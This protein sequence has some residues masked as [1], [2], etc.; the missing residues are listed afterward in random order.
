[1]L[2]R[3]LHPTVIVRGY[4]RALEAAVKVAEGLSFEI[5][6]KDRS[7]ML[8]VVQSCIGTKYTSRFGSLMAVSF[9][10][11]VLDVGFWGCRVFWGLRGYWG[12]VKPRLWHHFAPAHFS[13]CQA[14]D[15]KAY[16]AVL[17][18]WTPA[19]NKPRGG[20][21]WEGVLVVGF[22]GYK[23]LRRVLGFK[24]VLGLVK[25]RLRDQNTPADKQM[26]SGLPQVVQSCACFM[27]TSK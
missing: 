7:Q 27:D 12:L 6:T 17:G 26:S 19:S 11:G 10:E 16:K 25:P 3:N 2:E 1:M 9:G 22:L 24:R 4:T 14:G 13:K 15:H 23:G 21:Y 5:D 18:L 20:R 8:S